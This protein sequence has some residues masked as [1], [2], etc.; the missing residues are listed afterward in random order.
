MEAV[1]TPGRPLSEAAQYIVRRN[2]TWHE[3]HFAGKVIKDGNGGFDAD[4]ANP[5]K[6]SVVVFDLTTGAQYPFKGEGP[7]K[8]EAMIDAMNKLKACAAPKSPSEQAVESTMTLDEQIAFKKRELELL[9][10]KTG[11]D[12]GPMV[13]PSA[14]GRRITTGIPTSVKVPT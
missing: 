13:Q 2:A 3:I 1:K 4:P 6:V 7:S 5:P 14:T 9:M 10:E 12:P 11:K 8:E